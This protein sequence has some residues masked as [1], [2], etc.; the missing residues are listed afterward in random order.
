M[1]HGIHW[2]GEAQPRASD[3]DELAIRAYNLLSNGM[4]GIDWAGL[5]VVAACLGISDIEG[6]VHRLSVIKAYS[7]DKE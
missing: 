5:D 2:D 1:Q 3:G 7:P 4:G 6:L